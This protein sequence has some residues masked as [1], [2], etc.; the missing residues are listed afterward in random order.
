MF[1]SIGAPCAEAL[2][3][4][5]VAPVDEERKESIS[6]RQLKSVGENAS[7]GRKPSDEIS[8]LTPFTGYANFEVHPAQI[9]GPR[10]IHADKYGC[11]KI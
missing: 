9:E 7:T 3:A 4:H 2:K 1:S 6:L 10:K 11:T 8:K 5:P